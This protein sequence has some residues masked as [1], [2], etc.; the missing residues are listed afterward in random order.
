M[1]SHT[2][3]LHNAN[4]EEYERSFAGTEDIRTEVVQSAKDIREISWP[5]VLP[6]VDTEASDAVTDE[7]VEE[8]G[9]P[10]LYVGHLQINRIT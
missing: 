2:G 4:L 6:G 8:L 5:H 7:T 3:N 9:D 1:T 10:V